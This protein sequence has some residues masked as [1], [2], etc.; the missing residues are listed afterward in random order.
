MTQSLQSKYKLVS[1][2]E[3]PI[4][5]FGVDSAKVYRNERESA[6]AIRKSGL[7][8][9]QIFYTSK[10]PPS[11]MGYELAKKAIEE[12]IAAADLGYIDL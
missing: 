5:G 4:V 8:R 2:Y 12:S 9:S 11:S 3:I 10:V 7:D 1:G 6:A